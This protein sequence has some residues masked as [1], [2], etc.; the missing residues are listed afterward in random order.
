MCLT[1]T[2]FPVKLQLW[3]L[4]IT[5]TSQE[6]GK[7]LQGKLHVSGG[8]HS[9]TSSLILL[10]VTLS[11]W[12]VNMR[13]EQSYQCS[14]HTSLYHC[15]QCI[16]QLR[17]VLTKQ[18]FEPYCILLHHHI[19]RKL[20]SGASTL[21]N[22]NISQ[23]NTFLCGKIISF[24]KRSHKFGHFQ[25]LCFWQRLLSKT[26]CTAFKVSVYL[27]NKPRVYLLVCKITLFIL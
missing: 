18:Y 27:Y 15:F 14:N 3:L 17:A 16:A 24:L 23:K 9:N 7:K 5:F 25:D 4:G 10:I 19:M 6:R 13:S 12:T 20:Q 21:L 11:G 8:C 1:S 26:N 2:R 22:Q